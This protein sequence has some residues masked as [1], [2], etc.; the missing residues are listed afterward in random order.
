MCVGERFHDALPR[1]SV[2]ISTGSDSLPRVSVF[3][4]TD[5]VLVRLCCRTEDADYMFFRNN[6][7]D[8]ARLAAR[9][10]RAPGEQGSVFLIAIRVV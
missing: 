3:I 10:R 7:P 9:Q 1:I 2:F 6:A 5:T 8:G 4:S